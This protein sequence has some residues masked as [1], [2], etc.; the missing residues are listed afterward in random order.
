MDR[1][2][3]SILV[4]DVGT[5]GVRAAVVRYDASVTDVHHQEVLPQTPAQGFVEFDAGVMAPFSPSPAPLLTLGALSM[6]SASP[7]SAP[8]R[9]SGTG[10]RANRLGLASAGRI[11][12]LSACA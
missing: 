4:V 1:G 6:P 5:S 8:R 12:G 7:T 3:V 2:A 10:P 11:S 9:S